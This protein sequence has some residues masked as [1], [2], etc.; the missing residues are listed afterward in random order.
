MHTLD[1]IRQ[2]RINK[3]TAFK[4]NGVNPYPTFFCKKIAVAAARDSLDKIVAVAGRIFSLRGHGKLIFADL[5]DESG[6]IQLMLKADLLGKSFDLIKLI[7]A[8]DFLLAE[9]KVTKTISGEISIL[10]EK[11]QILTK[12]IRP[13]PEK[14]HGLKDV[15]ERYRQRYVDLLV[16]DGIKEI[17]LV[18][19]KV[20]QLLRKFLD[21]NGFLEVETPVLQQI[22]GGASAK[23]FITHHNALDND[24]YL[25]I[26]DELYLKRL[27]VGGFEKVY[28]MGK[29]FRNEGISRAHNP[30]FTQVEFY[31]AYVDYE[32]LMNFTE[33][34]LSGIIQEINGDLE[35]KHKNKTYHFKTPWLRIS[36]RDLLLKHLG[37]DINIVNNEQKLAAII[38]DKKLLPG[39]KTVGYG[40]TLD[41]LYK[42]DIRPHLDGPLFLIDHPVEMKPLAKRKDDDPSKAASFQLLVAGE[43]WLNAYNELNDP[44]DQ[45]ARWEAEMELGKKG[46]EDYQVID[47]DYIRAL[48]YGMPPTAGWGLG[49]DRLTAFLTDQST[50][51]DVILFPTLRPENKINVNDRIDVI[52]HVSTNKSVDLSTSREKALEILNQNI[53]NKNLIKHALA[54][55]AA[56]KALARYFKEDEN[57]WGLVGLLHD[58][59]WEKTKDNYQAHGKTTVEWLKKTGENNLLL[60]NAISSHNYINNKSAE[61][62]S[63]LDWS[64][65]CC[66]ELTGL[67][68]AVALILPGKKLADV[69]VESVLKKFPSKSFAAGV[70]R[71]QIKLC[72]EKLGIKLD[73]FV[74]IILIS[75]QKIAGDLGL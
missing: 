3:A 64:I 1:T 16:N 37:I 23:P 56:M 44:A 25:R 72:E 41:V 73:D 6:K 49:V 45:K 20:V 68:I 65:Y 29:D 7:D 11:F 40:Q 10:V 69:T 31:W 63:K 33:K 48:E 5:K 24:L 34:M 32:H 67:I 15:E 30:E 57:L 39:E 9:G 58:A 70:K 38:A 59:D 66:D 47:E 42:K 27:I 4:K 19:S 12:A 52:N 36:Y 71:E 62:N 26:S 74:K 51:K 2:E 18:R 50:I 54:V 55:E 75:M 53:S 61:P 35:V 21:E 14:W 43:E 22:Y 60:L 17:F 46:A 13:L 28:E 8:G